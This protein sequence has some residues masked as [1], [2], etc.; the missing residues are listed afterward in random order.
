MATATING[1]RI[2]GTPE[3]IA[4]IMQLLEVKTTITTWPPINIPFTQTS[5]TINPPYKITSTSTDGATVGI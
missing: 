5:P 4:K 3:E 2:D 1:V